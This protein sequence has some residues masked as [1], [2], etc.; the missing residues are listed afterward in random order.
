MDFFL[1]PVLS[2]SRKNGRTPEVVPRANPSLFQP[3]SQWA[4]PREAGQAWHHWFPQGKAKRSWNDW[5]NPGEGNWVW[6]DWCLPPVGTQSRKVWT[7]AE[8]SQESDL[9][10]ELNNFTMKV[11]AHA[12]FCQ[13]CRH[14][15]VQERY[16]FTCFEQKWFKKQMQTDH[17]QVKRRERARKLF[18]LNVLLITLSVFH[19]N[20]SLCKLSIPFCISIFVWDKRG[21]QTYKKGY[22]YKTH[23]KMA[24]NQ[25]HGT[26]KKGG[27]LK[28]NG[29]MD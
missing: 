25:T 20:S 7:D 8:R 24:N 16:D 11:R 18:K 14:R 9:T 13:Y 22:T 2:W 27:A 28:S 12:Y 23:R 26:E 5:C 17:L 19:H 1:G 4:H 29:F 15:D 6:N 10:K 3:G 21:K